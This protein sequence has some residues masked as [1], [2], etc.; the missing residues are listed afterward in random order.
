MQHHHSAGK[1]SI[2][3][4]GLVDQVSFAVQLLSLI[5]LFS[6]PWTA[7][8]QASLSFT[9]SQSLVKLMSIELVMPSNHL[10]LCCPLLLLPSIFPSVRVYSN[11]LALNI[12][13]PKYWSFSFNISS[14][15]EYSGLISFSIDQFD[16][17]AVQG[18]SRVF[19]NTIVQKHQL[20]DTHPSLWPNTHSSFFNGPAQDSWKNHS[21]DNMDLC[22]Q[23]NVSAFLI[24]CLGLSQ[25]FFQETGF[26]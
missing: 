25:L 1:D 14:S 8:C 4:Y 22:H 19:F 20:F 10:I 24:H 15:N 2:A 13:W 26:F 11:E 6:T 9:I 18:L 12:K 17:L 7:A 5:L 21:F 16:P 3:Q 23:S